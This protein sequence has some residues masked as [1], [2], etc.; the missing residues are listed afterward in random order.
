MRPIW[1]RPDSPLTV[2]HSLGWVILGVV[3]GVPIAASAYKYYGIGEHGFLN[4]ITYTMKCFEIWQ[5]IS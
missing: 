4:N 5:N 2:W 1:W 3:L